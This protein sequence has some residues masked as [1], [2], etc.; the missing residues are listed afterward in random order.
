MNT[1]TQK[2]TML[3]KDEK[4]HEDLCIKKYARYSNEAEDPELKQLFSTIGEHEK[5]HLNSINSM[6]NGQIPN[7]NQQQSQQGQQNINANTNN[8]NIGFIQNDSDLCQ[9]ALGTEKYVSSTYNSTIF[10]FKNP[11]AREVL[12]HIQKEEQE[13]GQQIFDYM[14]KKGYYTPQ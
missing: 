14:Y 11:S 9:D 8:S 13:H 4:A 5:Q 3:L 1:L 7:V 12:N 6:L 10:E 2:E